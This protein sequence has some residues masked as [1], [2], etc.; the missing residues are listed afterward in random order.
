MGAKRE[1]FDKE[2]YIGKKFGK[3]TLKDTYLKNNNRIAICECECGETFECMFFPL[4]NGIVTMCHECKVKEC[5]KDIINKKIGHLYVTDKHRICPNPKIKAREFFC[6]C[7]CGNEIWVQAGHLT[8]KKETARRKSCGCESHNKYGGMTRTLEASE[9]LL[10]CRTAMIQRCNNE[11]YVRS[12]NYGG[13]GITVCQEWLDS[14]DA[15]ISWAYANG[16]EENL[17]I[18][19]ID[20]NGNY[21]PSN[22]RWVDVVTQANN[23]RTTVYVDMPNGESIPLAIY[24]KEHGLRYKASYM[25]Y[26]ESEYKGTYHIP[27]QDLY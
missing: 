27:E 21:E 17:E 12:Y 5:Y 6:I 8:A 16:Y 23:K 15:F 13:R 19:R 22:C 26:Y 20:V 25:I 24:C 10:Q 7:D 14:P 4:K 1:K 2:K 11:N 3:L 18:D 9:R